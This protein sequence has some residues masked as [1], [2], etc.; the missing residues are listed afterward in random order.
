MNKINED[1]LRKNYPEVIRVFRSAFF[2]PS[3]LI[4]GEFLSEDLLPMCFFE[5][6]AQHL[7]RQRNFSILKAGAIVAGVDRNTGSFGP[8]Y[9]LQEGERGVQLMEDHFNINFMFCRIDLAAYG[10]FDGSDG[11]LF[12]CKVCRAPEFFG[13][14]HQAAFQLAKRYCNEGVNALADAINSRADFLEIYLK[15]LGWV[16]AFY[17]S[18]VY[19]SPVGEGSRCSDT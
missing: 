16:S 17:D 1:Q 3:M 4:R 18:P 13:V 6:G 14:T 12:S 9:I 7:L 19:N 15:W 8:I 10:Y 11:A 5:G 2:R